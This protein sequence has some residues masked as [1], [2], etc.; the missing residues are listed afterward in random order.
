MVKQAE[1]VAVPLCLELPVPPVAGGGKRE[2]DAAG[3]QVPQ[4]PLR[5]CWVGPGGLSIDEEAPASNNM[6][7]CSSNKPYVLR[8]GYPG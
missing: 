1:Q 5:S 6:R 3:V 7:S 2:R 8:S 4:Q